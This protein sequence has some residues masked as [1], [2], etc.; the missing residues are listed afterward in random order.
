MNFG[1]GSVDCKYREA[2]GN[3]T[4]QCEQCD[5]DKFNKGFTVS[6]QVCFTY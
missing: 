1:S 4:K 5:R 6:T 2:T 3:K